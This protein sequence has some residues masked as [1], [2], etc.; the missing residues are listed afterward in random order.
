[1]L[2][3][4]N[5]MTYRRDDVLFVFD[6]TDAIIIDTLGTRKSDGLER[7]GGRASPKLCTHLALV[8]SLASFCLESWDNLPTTGHAHPCSSRK[9][10]QVT[11]SLI[12]PPPP[13]ACD[14]SF[15]KRV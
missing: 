4:D 13:Q 9:S 10:F 15:W 7:H 8:P 3:Q 12:E 1:M 2:D 6:A 5:K 14:Y 11:L